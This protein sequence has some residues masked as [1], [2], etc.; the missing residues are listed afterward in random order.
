[1]QPTK[2]R[3]LKLSEALK[4]QYK[5]LKNKSMKNQKLINKVLNQIV[6]DVNEN[7]LT[8]IEELLTFV[9]VKYLKGFLSEFEF[10]P[11]ETV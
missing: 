4:T 3:Y 10:I 1:M 9:P 2:R 8:A 6:N 7:D 11:K 5:Q